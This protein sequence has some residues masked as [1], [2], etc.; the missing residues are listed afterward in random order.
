MGSSALSFASVKSRVIPR[1]PMIG[2][3]ALERLS[4]QLASSDP[5]P[6]SR[7]QM[8]G[9]TGSVAAGA[10]V[11]SLDAD[12]F[13][14]A[15]LEYLGTS[16]HIRSGGRSFVVDSRSFGGR[17]TIGISGDADAFTLELRG[18]TY[19]GTNIPADF[20][21]HISAA[22]TRPW[23][24]LETALAG[25][26]IEI[27]FLAWLEG[28][29]PA[30]KRVVV[31]EVESWLGL[32]SRLSVGG[33]A[34][35]VVG[36]DLSLE[37]TGSRIAEF[38][39]PDAKLAADRLVLWMAGPGSPTSLNRRISR[40]TM[41]QFVRDA[42]A[43]TLPDLTA[44]SG[45]SVAFDPS[46]FD[47]ATVECAQTSRGRRLAVLTADDTTGSGLAWARVA[48]RNGAGSDAVPLSRP[49]FALD[50]DSRTFALEAD[51][52]E[53]VTWVHRRG[54]S[55]LVGREDGA[56]QFAMRGS[57]GTARRVDFTTRVLGVA[58]PLE[59][60]VAT[61]IIFPQASS[62]LT[63]RPGPFS[64]N[65]FAIAPPGPIEP[66]VVIAD[67]S[68]MTITRREDMLSATFEFY[69]LKLVPGDTKGF[70]LVARD[71][72]GPSYLVVEL[73]PQHVLE[74]AFYA[75]ADWAT[76]SLSALLTKISAA[77]VSAKTPPIRALISDPTRLAFVVPAT[78]LAQGIPYTVEGL[79]NWQP[80]AHSVVPGA[81]DEVI[82]TPLV[83]YGMV[84]PPQRGSHDFPFA[85]ETSIEA[86]WGLFLS[87][88]EN[89][90]YWEHR[91]APF[92]RDF[93]TELWHTTLTGRTVYTG[94][95]VDDD[96]LGVAAASVIKYRP[97]IRVV[98]ARG[99]GAEDDPLVPFRNSFT[100]PDITNISG[101]RNRWALVDITTNYQH[102]KVDA[103]RLT[104]SPLG[105]W[106]DLKGQWPVTD[107]MAAGENIETA[108]EAW[109]HRATMGRD[110]F[111]K[112]VKAGRL[113]P[114]GHRASLVTI[115]ERQFQNAP[116]GRRTAY[117][118]QRSFIF[119][120]EFEK[121]Y[122]V[123]DTSRSR[124][125][126]FKKVTL[127]T[128]VTPDLKDPLTTRVTHPTLTGT[129][130]SA[131]WP[132]VLTTGAEF[133]FSYFAED[134]D[135]RV[136]EF[137][138][139]LIWMAEEYAAKI[140]PTGTTPDQLHIV[141]EIQI[142]LSAMAERSISMSGQKMAF[143]E[144]L[145]PGVSRDRRV[146]ETQTIKLTAENIVPWPEWLTA[147]YGTIHFHPRLHRAQVRLEDVEAL[148]NAS[149]GTWIKLYSD[150][151]TDGFAGNLAFGRVFAVISQNDGAIPVAP[152]TPNTLGLNIPP[153]KA[154]G[155]ATPNLAIRGLSATHG[156]F[157]GD[158]ES[159]G[160]GIAPL[161]ASSA[162]AVPAGE[163][164][165]MDF[166]GGADPELFGGITLTDILKGVGIPLDNTPLF[167]DYTEQRNGET[168]AV[169]Q[170]EWTND[171]F[172]TES[173]IFIKN[174]ATSLYLRTYL[175]K[176]LTRIDAPPSSG[177]EGTLN[178]FTLSLFEIINVEFTSFAFGVANGGNVTVD[179]VIN[180]IRFS[181][182]LEFI[183][184][185][186]EIM[187]FTSD[188]GG[189]AIDI[190]GSGLSAI[191][192][193]AL[194][195]IAV[196]IFSLK[197]MAITAGFKLPF[198]GSPLR[199]P[200]SFC[201][202]E[203]PFEL[204]VSGF[205]GGGY[206]LVE[207]QADPD[208]ALA[209]L[210]L[211]L[212][213]GISCSIDLCGI[214]SGGVEI[215]GGVLIHIE[216]RELSFTAFFRMG[217]YLDILGIISCSI[218]FNLSLEYQNKAAAGGDTA[219]LIGEASLTIEI[220][221]LF[222]SFSVDLMVHKEFEGD[223]PRFGD[224]MDADEWEQYCEAFGLAKLG[225]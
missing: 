132:R 185:L 143:C 43:W 4:D 37:L 171:R 16:A 180:D 42:Q 225:A 182:A 163:V 113:F 45:N 97:K 61:P 193:I 118:I 83:R 90:E 176:N 17:P 36:P 135:G 154:G 91:T 59:G 126:P 195:D 122:P 127:R 24:R 7:R 156:P 77:V 82:S 9:L 116:D 211:S 215:K 148:M 110:Q 57:S 44:R 98:W 23:M 119:V 92:T 86:P 130:E 159:Y 30:R 129:A 73:P 210:E 56:P 134:W 184:Q 39:G 221:I 128:R 172:G 197:N 167:D 161:T 160:T 112:I 216:G 222:F 33:H 168:W 111:V 84:R 192:T 207:L 12:A 165:P 155:F 64:F 204:A 15:V 151:L 140:P 175:E 96:R 51:V 31:N 75:E 40:R 38:E 11:T 158:P 124:S 20:R 162:L 208:N 138:S 191:V 125:N 22:R 194:P 169:Y 105:A 190:D 146:L 220:E 212:E 141:R 54:R 189:F 217:G 6:I 103:R 224:W 174:D 49:R 196:G 94:N 50:C 27:P 108:V 3:S 80:Y 85:P 123:G 100:T 183:N 19:P 88:S 70:K 55:L 149:S 106:L 219:M 209:L 117:L 170:Y 76:S 60:V 13:C 137:S 72:S 131:F 187:N 133:V 58:A 142:A 71:V 139:P 81:R 203:K 35:V 46:A 95:S 199:F 205:G 188:D 115:T 2:R 8:L 200:F 68:T 157:G 28:R 201:T 47:I 89:Y 52:T 93:T 26:L 67:A 74:E 114:W 21:L 53:A 144:P 104:L 65:P 153:D 34:D 29:R 145:P 5:V 10:A 14:P 18:A 223:D 109:E 218:V 178:N 99:W 78:I 32:S 179:P 152:P 87:P 181:G 63:P 66:P 69:N 177:V 213:F 214:A 166:F 206:F 164:D 121:S 198:D 173:D 1:P 150:Y 62:T 25:A 101:L 186:R 147:P 102:D 41:I 107:Y 79:L 120:R 136:V 202:R 48:G